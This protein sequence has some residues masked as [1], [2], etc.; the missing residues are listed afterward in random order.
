[1]KK[2]TVIFVFIVFMS[3]QEAHG[4]EIYERA[5]QLIY[6]SGRRRNKDDNEQFLPSLNKQKPKRKSFVTPRGNNDYNR[7]EGD[8]IPDG[9]YFK[10]ES[11]HG[12]AKQQLELLYN[13]HYLFIFIYRYRRNQKK[14]MISRMNHLKRLQEHAIKCTEKQTRIIGRQLEFKEERLMTERDRREFRRKEQEKLD[15]RGAYLRELRMKCHNDLINLMK[16]EQERRAKEESEEKRRREEELKRLREMEI[17]RCRKLNLKR[18]FEHRQRMVTIHTL[19]E[20]E[21]E[22]IRNERI[23]DTNRKLKESERLADEIK[24]MKENIK[25][26]DNE[27]DEITLLGVNTVNGGKELLENATLE[28]EENM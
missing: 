5:E 9:S 6:P 15:K 24:L 13:Y 3:T 14:Q 2:E 18:R 11:T 8:G 16:E 17:E 1:M 19:K 12:K 20:K 4:D 26:L 23:E 10:Y 28:V 7:N 25:E 27:L 22:M 21:I